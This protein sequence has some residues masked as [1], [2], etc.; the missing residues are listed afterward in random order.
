MRIAAAQILSGPD[1]AANLE[2]VTRS[3][4]DAAAAGARIVAFPE[5]TMRANRGGNRTC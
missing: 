5:A 3:I 1:P 2:L 4:A